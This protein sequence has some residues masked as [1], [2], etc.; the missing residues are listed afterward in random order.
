VRQTEPK[1]SPA[2]PN[3]TDMTFLIIS[4]AGLIYTGGLLA[5]VGGFWRAREGFEDEKG[6]HQ[7][8]PGA[9]D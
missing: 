6:F 8:N 3:P 7:G 1:F 5:L 9:R 4:I 2:K